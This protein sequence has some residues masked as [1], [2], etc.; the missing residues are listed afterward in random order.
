MTSNVCQKWNLYNGAV[1][2]VV[3]IIFHSGEGPSE[4]GSNWPHMVLVNFPEYTGPE[5]FQDQPHLVPVFPVTF[6][7]GGSSDKTQV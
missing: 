4:D 2:L 7:E 3:S 6:A 1:G 5:F